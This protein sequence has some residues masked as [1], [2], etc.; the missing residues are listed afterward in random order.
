MEIRDLVQSFCVSLGMNNDVINMDLLL[1]HVGCFIV[2]PCM[3][4]PLI[5]VYAVTLY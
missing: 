4:V 3:W 5:L 2:L 1:I